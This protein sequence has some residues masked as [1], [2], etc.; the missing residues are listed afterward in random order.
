M[1]LVR[2]AGVAIGLL[3]L[4]VAIA[5]FAG[6]S[7]HAGAWSTASTAASS[8]SHSLDTFISGV[9][10]LATRTY[11]IFAA[12]TEWIKDAMSTVAY[13]IGLV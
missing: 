1:G 2:Q 8:L 6:G 12:C 5:A 3:L 11:E 4:C 13:E 10:A 9:G 7:S